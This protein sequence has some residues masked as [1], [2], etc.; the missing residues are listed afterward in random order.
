MLSTKAKQD[1]FSK[2]LKLI[3]SSIAKGV[4]NKPS[5]PITE[6]VNRLRIFGRQFGKKNPQNLK[7]TYAMTSTSAASNATY[8]NIRRYV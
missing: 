8:K 1:H 3:I 4:G 2:K 7:H 6:S 5:W